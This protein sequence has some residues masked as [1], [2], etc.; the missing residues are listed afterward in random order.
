V[1]CTRLQLVGA[2]NSFKLEPYFG[3]FIAMSLKS[4]KWNIDREAQEVETGD[5]YPGWMNWV[6]K[7]GITADT[8]DLCFENEN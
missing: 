3:F 5:A 4:L 7:E 6:C 1:F 2:F 8:L